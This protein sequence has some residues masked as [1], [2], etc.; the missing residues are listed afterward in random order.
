MIIL[1]ILAVASIVFIM[2]LSHSKADE[3]KPIT[4]GLISITGF[5]IVV[6]YL[7]SLDTLHRYFWIPIAIIGAFATYVSTNE[8]H[9]IKHQQ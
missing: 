2:A 1:P 5:G 9:K 6:V 4:A 8:G 7:F 3:G